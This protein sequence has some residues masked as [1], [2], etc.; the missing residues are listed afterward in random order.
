MATPYAESLSFLLSQLGAHVARRFADELA[1]SGVTARGFG[2]L[3]NVVDLGPRSQ[4]QLAD[5][6]GIHR[7][8]MVGLIDE[9]EHDG[10]VQRVRNAA[11]RRS[12]LIEATPSG[13]RAVSEV[14]TIV[15]PLDAEIAD[16]LDE[17]ATAV[18]T[19]TLRD[20]ARAAGLTP[21][22]HPHLGGHR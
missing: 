17:D 22:V 8:N 15:P 9:M 2:V 16:G 20:L 3:S 18:L 7:N 14:N 12:F 21:G 11:D 13:R 10:L 6:L 4:Q 19:A 1:E 5:E